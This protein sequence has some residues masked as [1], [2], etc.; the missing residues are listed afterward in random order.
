[1]K[2]KQIDAE[3]YDSSD[4]LQG[5]LGVMGDLNNRF[6]K[7]RISKVL[8]IYKPGKE[9]SVVDFGCAWGSFSFAAAPLCK[10]A[11]GIDFSRKSLEIC[12]ELSKKYNF[13]NVE[14]M[15]A[16]VRDTKLPADCFQAVICADL[17]EHLYP[18]DFLK[19]LS[20]AKRVLKTGGR[21]VIWT[22]HRGHFLEIMK[23]HDFLLKKDP[24]HVDYKSMDFLVS[25]LE[26]AGFIVE[27]KYYTESHIPVLAVVEK[28]FMRFVPFLRRRIA[29]SAV[30]A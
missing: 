19:M 8:Q 25:S 30:K 17:V 20:E 18:E 7:Y 9:D 23:N 21:L 1:M 5:L 11:I 12:R 14:F 27:K 16:D 26:S 6:Q 15:L 29:I 10:K 24:S 2:N 3:Y 4:Y 13:D 28:L 22:P